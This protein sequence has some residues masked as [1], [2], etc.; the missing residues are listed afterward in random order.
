MNESNRP[1]DPLLIAYKVRD[2]RNFEQPKILE[3]VEREPRYL[4]VLWFLQWASNPSNHPGGIKKFTS[5]FIAANEDKLGTP[6]MFAARES[7]ALTFEDFLKIQ[8]EFPTR[9]WHDRDFYE[10]MKCDCEQVPFEDLK[11]EEF[12]RS[13]PAK[14]HES[15]LEAAR[16]KLFQYFRDLCED[17]TCRFETAEKYS[18]K[19]APWYWPTVCKDLISW[20]KLRE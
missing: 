12:R 2:I 16:T 17:P 11:Q 20:L 10:L 15:V 6:A 19:G 1:I 4:E 3:E 8:D 14:L 9:Y 13:S 7:K 5:D 18:G